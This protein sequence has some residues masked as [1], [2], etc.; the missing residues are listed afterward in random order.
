[1][2]MSEFS[3]FKGIVDQNAILKRAYGYDITP[4]YSVSA[5]MVAFAE[6]DSDIFN[7][8]KIGYTPNT[9]INLVFDSVRFAC[10]MAPKIGRYREYKIDEREVVCEVPAMDGSV[11]SF[12]DSSGN[13]V[14]GCV[15]DDV[16][17]YE[18]GLGYAETF[19][20]NGMSGKMRC[21]LSGYQP[22]VEQTVV[23]DPYEHVDFKVSFPKNGDLYYSLKYTIQNDDYLETMLFLTFVVDEVELGGGRKKYMLHGRTHGSV[24]FFDL[25]Q[26][27]KYSEMIHPDIGDVVEID[28]PDDSNREKYEI[29]D[30]FDRQ[31]TQD[32]INPL[33]HK[34]VWKCKARRYI[35][36]YEDATPEA[37]EADKRLDEK[38]R[39]DAVVQ[40]EVAESVSLYENVDEENGVK[41]DAVYGGYDGV[42][43]KYDTQEVL[44]NHVRYDFI[45][46]QECIDV[47]RFGCGSRLVTD[48]YEL[49]FVAK[50][51]DGYVVAQGSHG[52]AVNMCTF[53]CGTKWLKASGS[54]VVFVNV[55]GESC[56]LATDEVAN[57]GGLEINLDDLYRST[58]DPDRPQNRNGDNFVKFKNTRTLLFATEDKLFAKLADS[59]KTYQLI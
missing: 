29:T 36:S 24:L 52:P 34:Y 27:Q 44:D 5:D 19:T 31:L 18:L 47:M 15:S 50:S 28:F 59:G 22:G 37:N 58:V 41:Q 7:L 55:D 38:R 43:D 4:D 48:G 30:C 39:Y 9:E 8:N 11:T 42:V 12:T 23:C 51:G 26:L 14:S 1:M 10:D 25:D 32:G 3:D 2:N 57:A 53:E 46:G 6:V 33:L 40:E 17:P 21:V 16:W 54:Q 13:V 49:V 56:A 20:C 35:N 45:E